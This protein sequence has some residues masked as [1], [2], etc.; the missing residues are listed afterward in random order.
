MI[1]K[2]T[3]NNDDERD[4]FLTNLADLC[5][6]LLGS[7][8]PE[9][10]FSTR[11]ICFNKN[12]LNLGDIDAI[13]PIGVNGIFNK[14]IEVVTRRALR[15]HIYKNKKISKRQI[16]FVQGLG[17]EVNL[18]RLRERV[19][20][21]RRKRTA[22]IKFV[23]FIDFKQAYDSVKHEKLFEKLKKMGTPRRR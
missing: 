9:E 16:G 2:E 1:L 3:E 19:N 10:I 22:S 18:V 13:R 21:L 8:L 5:N 12:A 15:Q 20:E 6:Q 11:L 14:V 7:D 23:L 4:A 17:C